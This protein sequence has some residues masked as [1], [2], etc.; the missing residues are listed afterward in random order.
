MNAVPTMCKSCK[1]VLN[2]NSLIESVDGQPLWKCEFC[3][4]DNK[5]DPQDEKPTQKAV[6]YVL[7][8]PDAE[9]EGFTPG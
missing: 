9:M 8:A 3:M 7:E 6:N 5:I 2:H 4:A 1:G